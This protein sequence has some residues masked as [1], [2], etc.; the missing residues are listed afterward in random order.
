MYGFGSEILDAVFQ[1]QHWLDESNKIP[2]T[3]QFHNQRQGLEDNF[4]F[5]F[6]LL[7]E[8]SPQVGLSPKACRNP[9]RAR[10]N[11]DLLSNVY[12]Q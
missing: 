9:S 10:S 8:A 3:I 11:Q 2:E 1:S 12:V 5:A 7:G 6:F 4:F